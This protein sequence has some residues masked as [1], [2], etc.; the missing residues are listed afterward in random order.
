MDH[1]VDPLAQHVELGIGDQRR[2]LDE[3]VLAEVE[4]GH[5]TVDPYQMISHADSLRPSRRERCHV[6]S[7]SPSPA[8]TKLPTLIVRFMAD[9]S[10]LGL[11][12]VK[13]LITDEAPF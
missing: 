3:L 9:T 10:R 12:L 1:Q 11:S 5:L 8:G 6:P 7:A 4:T 13:L 2:D